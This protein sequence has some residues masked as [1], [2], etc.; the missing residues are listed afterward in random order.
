MLTLLTNNRNFSVFMFTQALSNLGDSVRMVIMPLLVLRLTGS[1]VYVTA[2]ALLGIVPYFLF[3]LPFGAHLD[4]WDRRR[5]MFLADIGRGLLVLSIPLVWLCHGP[6][7]ATLFLATV[8]LSLLSSIFGAGA[9]AMTP[10]LVD[11]ANLTNAY[12]LFEAAESAAWVAGP[13]IAGLIAT[14]FGATD[15]LA[16]DAA[17]FFISA[18]G[19][20]SLKIAPADAEIL[21]GIIWR[22]VLEGLRFVASQGPL[23]QIQIYWSLYGIIGYGTVTGLI[24]AGSHGGAS[25]SP[26]GSI[27]VSAYAAG[28]L[29]GT[30]VAGRQKMAGFIH[31]IPLSL[32]VLA[33][34]GILVATGSAS[35][36]LTG[37]LLIGAAEGFFLVLYLSQR[38]KATPHE[39]MARV[40]TITELLA[41]VANGISVTWMGVA[42][43]W[44]SGSG[45][46]SLVALLAF[47]LA[48]L[49]FAEGRPSPKTGTR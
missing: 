40:G 9:G 43:E 2:M 48:G 34:G 17:S 16:V 44:W 7:L 15:A 4:Q 8:P 39:M 13:A 6:V 3:Q 5:T 38:A 18:S 24:Y 31:A 19:L 23:R 14:S 26:L 21:P 33:G 41:G 37:A 1:A 30:L 42:L 45:A 22:R 28:S 10:M 32:L 36:I 47:A 27:A 12:S 35:G 29:L 11:R 20:I 25:S 49:V 46:F